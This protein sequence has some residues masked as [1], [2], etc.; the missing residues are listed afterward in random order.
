[1]RFHDFLA[2]RTIIDEL[3]AFS[4]FVLLSLAVSNVT[5]AVMQA[6][7]IEFCNMFAN[8]LIH[9]FLRAPASYFHFHCEICSVPRELHEF[10]VK[11]KIGCV[12]V[13]FVTQQDYH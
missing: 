2:N 10:V 8:L 1:M 3:P 4:E 11:T 12:F 9:R 5:V 7:S 13:I 6:I